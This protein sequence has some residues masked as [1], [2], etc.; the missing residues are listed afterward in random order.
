MLSLKDDLNFEI[1]SRAALKHLS[2]S[3]EEGESEFRQ[4][5]MIVKILGHSL[6]AS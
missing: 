4:D 3:T 6:V 2:V 1:N 5:F